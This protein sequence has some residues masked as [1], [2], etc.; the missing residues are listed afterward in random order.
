[1]ST[2]DTNDLL[3]FR[4]SLVALKESGATH[5]NLEAARQLAGERAERLID[6]AQTFNNAISNVG[7]AV[8]GRIDG[9]HA[10]LYERDSANYISEDSYATRN[11]VHAELGFLGKMAAGV[12]KLEPGG[13]LDLSRTETDYGYD[14]EEAATDRM[15]GLDYVPAI[16]R[17]EAE[18]ETH[19]YRVSRLLDQLRDAGVNID[20]TFHAV[21]QTHDWDDDWR[22]EEANGQELLDQIEANEQRRDDQ[23]INTAPIEGEQADSTRPQSL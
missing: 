5:I 22:Y 6:R 13:T 16:E 1:M 17:Q 19:V 2:R 12:A 18:H 3:A 8:Q 15:S 23:G 9:L 21:P 20:T 7:A 4:A 14:Q 11:D 10:R